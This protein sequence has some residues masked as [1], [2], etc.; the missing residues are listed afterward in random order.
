MTF[1]HRLMTALDAAQQNGAHALPLHT[2]IRATLRRA[3]MKGQVFTSGA[4]LADAVC[5]YAP[6]RRAEVLDF[7]A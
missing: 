1:H 2:A 5:R 7:A 4:Q 3:N 6:V